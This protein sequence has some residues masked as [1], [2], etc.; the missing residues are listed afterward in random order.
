MR[1]RKRTVSN[2]NR[3]AEQRNIDKRRLTSV[4]LALRLSQSWVREQKDKRSIRSQNP[5]KS[6]IG[7]IDVVYVLEGEPRNDRICGASLE[8]RLP[9]VSPNQMNLRTGILPR[10]TQHCV[11]SID[12]N[13]LISAC[14]KSRQV[15]SGATARID[16]NFATGDAVLDEG[17]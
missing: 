5:C 8:R 9:E 17:K 10:V 7:Y 2:A 11:R 14:G 16:D 6:S 1:E 3:V 4:V 15:F 13:H 12:S